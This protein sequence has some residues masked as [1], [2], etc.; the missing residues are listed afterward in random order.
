MIHRT[1]IISFVIFCVILVACNSKNE[2]VGVWKAVSVDMPFA[3][4]KIPR[5]E[6]DDLANYVLQ[7]YAP[8]FDL[9]SDGGARIFG[10]GGECNGTW[11]FKENIVSIQCPDSF[12]DLEK[13]GN[14]LINLPDRTFT[15]ERQ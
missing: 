5:E 3:E 11:S 1:W 9:N 13:S 14:Q 4:G 7:N 10:G 6:W 2:L 8:G 12:V 15:F